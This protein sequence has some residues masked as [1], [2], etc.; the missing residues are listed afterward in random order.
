MYEFFRR[1]LVIVILIP[2]LLK[3]YKLKFKSNKVELYLKI[4]QS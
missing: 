2:K 1:D 3:I 4:Y